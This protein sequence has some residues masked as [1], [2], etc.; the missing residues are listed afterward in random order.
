[1]PIYFEELEKIIQKWIKINQLQKPT[2]E[3]ASWFVYKRLMQSSKKD[4]ITN[5][6]KVFESI[7]IED[8]KWNISNTVE[9]DKYFINIKS[10]IKKSRL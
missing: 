4:M 3:A 10:S 5:I 1:M 2:K 7:T 8:V 9:K 6:I